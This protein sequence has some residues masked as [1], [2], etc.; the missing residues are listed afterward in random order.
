MSFWANLPAS[1]KNLRLLDMGVGWV[2][3]EDI[4]DGDGKITANGSH[5]SLDQ[6]LTAGITIFGGACV[7]RFLMDLYFYI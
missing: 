6:I 5:T 4:V 1:A 7:L 2:K 3:Y